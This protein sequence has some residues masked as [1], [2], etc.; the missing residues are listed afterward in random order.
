MFLD[1]I[2][3]AGLLNKELRKYY[4]AEIWNGYNLWEQAF[5]RYCI[6]PLVI[7]RWGYT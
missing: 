6:D 1:I 7:D 3:I 5:R 2:I 4:V